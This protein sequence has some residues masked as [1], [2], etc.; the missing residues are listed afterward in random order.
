MRKLNFHWHSSFLG[1]LIG[2]LFL[3]GC[4]LNLPQFT[5]KTVVID[6]RPLAEGLTNL[7]QVEE[8]EQ[9]FN[10][11]EGAVRLILLLSPT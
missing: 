5:S 1:F 2:L 9:A 7:E 10:Q 3:V 8:L 11:D 4:G 6:G